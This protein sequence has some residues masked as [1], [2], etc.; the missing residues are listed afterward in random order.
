LINGLDPAEKSVRVYNFH[1]KVIHEATEVLAAMGL[2]NEKLLTPEHIYIR[3]DI[4][5]TRSY[6][7]LI[8]KD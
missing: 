1:K 8:K 5:K 4:N 6:S 7:D 3:T 2:K